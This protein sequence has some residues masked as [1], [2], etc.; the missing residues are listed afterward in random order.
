MARGD[1]GHSR[2]IDVLALLCLVH[3]QPAANLI[4]QAASLFDVSTRSVRQTLADLEWGG[5]V[6]RSS[7]V[8]MRTAKG[9]AAL[10]DP[11]LALELISLPK[12]HREY[13]DALKDPCSGDHAAAKVEQFRRECW[14]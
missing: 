5:F 1:L 11:N 3:G 14:R 7:G 8:V 12:R 2:K 6:R 4:G 13:R 9:E 10:T